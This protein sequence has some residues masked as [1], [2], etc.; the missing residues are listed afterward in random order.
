MMIASTESQ[1][2]T[3]LQD[4]VLNVRKEAGWTSH[5]VVARVRGKL[6]GMKLG[7]AGTL[8]PAA[9]G[10]L[11]LLVGRGTRI[12]EYLL[13]WD[14]TYLAGLRLGETTDTQDATGTVLQRS[15]ITALTEAR[16][17]ETIAGF[18]GRIQQVPPMYSAVKVGGVPLYKAARAGKD[19]ARQ[20]RE[21][22][23]FRLEVVSIQL[24]DVMLRVVCSKGTYIRTLCADIG[25]K[26][27]VGGHMATLIRERVGPL[28]VEQSLTVNEVETRLT[29]GTLAGS[30]L[31]LD[32]ALVGLPVCIIGRETARQVVHGMAVPTADV[33][34]WQGLPT[35]LPE[36]SGGP[37]R[38]KDTAGRLLAIGTM[39]AGLGD[40][41]R[42]P[43]E[44]SIA[45]SK[46]LVEDE[47]QGSSIAN[48]IEE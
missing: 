14:K 20:P 37:I 32:E 2:A 6:R 41:A 5:D 21:V 29:Q 7:H 22:T 24:P 33:L 25:E 16:I 43:G 23:V 39:P 48:S 45:M 27:G 1:T 19:V 26:L 18:E 44:L 8:D 40:Q 34:S 31:T 46:V 4:G 11:P 28:M 38:I 30:M 13:E 15:P 3:M 9:T 10:V 47:S 42:M 36:A 17:R 12:A 35:I